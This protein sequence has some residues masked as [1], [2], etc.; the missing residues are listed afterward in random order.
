MLLR[1]RKRT[2]DALWK[3]QKI[4]KLSEAVSHLARPIFIYSTGM[5]NF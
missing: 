4:G 3:I 5:L 2:C 1:A